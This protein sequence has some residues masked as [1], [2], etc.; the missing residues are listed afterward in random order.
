MP[1]SP[2]RRNEPPTTSSAMPGWTAAVSSGGRF[3]RRPLRRYFRRHFRRYLRRR[4][5]R[6][7]RGRRG[8]DLRYNLTISFEEAAFGLETKIQIP[9]HHLQR[10]RRQRGEEGDQSQDLP[11]LPGGRPG[12]LPAGFLLPDPSLSR[13]WRRGAGHR[14]SLPRVPR[15]GRVQGKK[16]ALPENSRRGRNRDP[17]Q[18]QRRRGGRQPGGAAG[19]SLCR[20]HRQGAPD[21]PAGRAGRDLRESRSPFVQAALGCE[22]EVPTL[23]GKVKLK[24]PA[25]TQS[26]KVL[27]LAG[28]GIPQLQGYGRGDQLVVPRVETPRT[29]PRGSGNS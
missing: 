6:R 20:H 11:D 17:P 23:E 3:R 4:L 28:K 9:R 2:T 29:S 1:S 27:K 25:G 18:A 15:P 22:L 10:L 16:P 14:Q 7:G 13:L 24:V 8:D 12:S 5:A 26:G 21:L 19:R